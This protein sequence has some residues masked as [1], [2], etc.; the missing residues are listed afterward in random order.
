MKIIGENVSSQTLHNE[1]STGQNLK[2]NINK[3]AVCGT[4]R[5]NQI[6]ASKID[7]R[8]IKKWKGIAINEISRR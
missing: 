1:N 8:T 7:L 5:K 4:V 6:P 2:Y 3:I